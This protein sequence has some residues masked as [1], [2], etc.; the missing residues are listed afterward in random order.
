MNA[1]NFTLLLAVFCL[2][3]NLSIAQTA[4]HPKNLQFTIKN[5]GDQTWGVF[6]KPD[7]SINPSDRAI[8]GTGQVTIVA[9][10][11]FEY[12]NL[13]NRGG[14]W[15]E[16]ARVDGPIEASEMTY[17]SFGFVQDVP[18]LQLFT[19]EETMLFSFSADERFSGTFYLFENNNDPFSAPN[20]Y[21][22]NPGNDIG[23][24]DFLANQG[25]QYY[26]YAG[27]YYSD[28]LTN[29]SIIAAKKEIRSKDIDN[30]AVRAQ[31]VFTKSVEND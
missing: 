25:M 31:A 12:T 9:P 20:S 26:T 4:D 22:N 28:E 2:S 3:F 27:N 6:V 30:E 14:T 8:A 10:I 19:E 29:P 23:M 13:E 16:N 1:T 15:V 7:Q 17:V 11:D 21:G 5:I 18:K 24:V